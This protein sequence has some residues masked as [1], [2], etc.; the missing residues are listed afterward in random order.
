VHYCL[1]FGFL[2]AAFGFILEPKISTE[3]AC[4][5]SLWEPK[6][7]AKTAHHKAF[8]IKMQELSTRILLTEEQIPL[9]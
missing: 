5:L 7:L 6:Q 9:I 2:P 4:L 1:G 8:L 3:G